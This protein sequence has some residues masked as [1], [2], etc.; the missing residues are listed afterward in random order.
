MAKK[1]SGPQ[2]LTANLL[3]EGTVVFLDAA[4]AW[5]ASIERARVAHSDD[6]VAALEAKGAEAVGTNLVVDPYL[7]ELDTSNG[8]V[9]PVEF[10][11]RMRI[12]GPS[13]DLGFNREVEE[14]AAVAA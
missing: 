10:R 4:G 7:V 14:H 5:A 2:V 9:S 13:I 11:E 3:N 6:E 8:S 1:I 12:A